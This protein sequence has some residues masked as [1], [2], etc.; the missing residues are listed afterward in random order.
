M[1]RGNSIPIIV[2]EF[3]HA[4]PPI[5]FANYRSAQISLLKSSIPSSESSR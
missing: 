1:M 2:I 5:H 3:A 4:D